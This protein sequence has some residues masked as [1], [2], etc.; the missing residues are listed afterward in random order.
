MNLF[1]AIIDTAAAFVRRNPLTCLVILLLA[2]A[3]PAVL[4]GIAVFILYLFLGLVLL[5]ALLM[6]LFRWRMNKV[7]RQMEEQFG[8]QGGFG[9][10]PFAGRRSRTS[11][12][13]EVK[14]F[15]TRGTPEKRVSRSVGDYVEFEETKDGDAQ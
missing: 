13:G 11:A 15:K 9:A 3:A 10:D 5:S 6:F 1:M 4:K 2:I 7:R 14:I 12:E 8:P